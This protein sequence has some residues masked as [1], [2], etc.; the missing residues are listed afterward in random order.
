[1]E[2]IE[3][4]IDETD[5]VSGIEAI[6]V[7]EN[8]A[9]ESDFVALK[10]QEFK[11]AEVDQEK[12]ILMGAALIPNKPIYRQSGEQEYY[13]YFSQATVRKASE[14]FFING[15]QNNS[16]LEHELQLK[17]LTAVESWIVESEQDKSRMYDLNVPMGTW[18]VSMKV[19][20][21]DVWKKVKAGEVKGFSIEG[22]F[23]DKLE[24]PNEPVKQSKMSKEEVAEAKIEELRQLFSNQK[25][26]LGVIQDL[27][28][29]LSEAPK[30]FSEANR[31]QSNMQSLYNKLYNVLD[32]KKSLKT[33][34]SNFESILNG[35]MYIVDEGGKLINKVESQSKELG[36]KPSEIKGYKELNKK[37]IESKDL[38]KKLKTSEKAANN[39]LK[40]LKV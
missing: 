32:D 11:L 17:G 34:L 23:A 39:I 7:V 19:N 38:V 4:F 27:N 5:E 20:N 6:S 21:D 29:M 2:I 26:E 18:M 3:L 35:V 14:L 28:K 8:P 10:K 37:I 24:R 12:R 33:Q 31:T 36:I 13:I 1:M 16:T 40:D 30:R 9:I 22:Y 25:V 15:N